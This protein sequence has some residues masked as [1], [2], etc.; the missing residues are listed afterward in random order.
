M[1]GGG[2]DLRRVGTMTTKET[3]HT[4]GSFRK[5]LF[6][7][8]GLVLAGALH[9]FAGVIGEAGDDQIRRAAEQ[10]I[11]SNPFLTVF[12]HVVVDVD[13][14]Y[15][16]LRGS[17]ERRHRRE[18]IAARVARL[19][20]VLGVRNEIDVQSSSPADDSL[21]R[22]LFESIYYGG[23]LAPNDEP[24]WQVQIVVDRQRVILFGDV[25][26]GAGQERIEA[27]ARNLGALAVDTRPEDRQLA[28]YVSPED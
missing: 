19:P 1:K 9:V 26:R 17:V 11:R 13:G 14:G 24:C 12:D 5:T 10:A 2:R 7:V 3:E 18:A 6:G 22:R 4:F 25:P 20:G 21:R 8:A 28:Q 16:Q 27:I 23:V 15:V